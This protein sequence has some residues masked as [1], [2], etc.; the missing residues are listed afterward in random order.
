MAPRIPADDLP[1]D[2]HGYREYGIM[3]HATEQQIQTLRKFRE[4]IGLSDFATRAHT[5][6]HNVAEAELGAM[7]R[8]TII[9]FGIGFGVMVTANAVAY[10]GSVGPAIAVLLQLLMVPFGIALLLLVVQAFRTTAR[11]RW[12]N[13]L[14]VAVLLL[15]F[16]G[17]A[18]L[19]IGFF[20]LPVAVGLLILS[21]LKLWRRKYPDADA[22]KA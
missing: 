3:L 9:P 8:T 11:T 6:V 10:L 18:I 4:S 5:S 16:S 1:H 15:M 2:K 13:L 17:L 22:R 20:T 7:S 19:S 12:L 21:A 14:A